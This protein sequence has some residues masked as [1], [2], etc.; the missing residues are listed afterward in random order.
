VSEPFF[1]SVCLRCAYAAFPA[2]LLCPSCGEERWKL[3]AVDEG[4]VESR[5]RLHRAPGRNYD[6]PVAIALVRV[7]DGPLVVARLEGDVASG[8]VTL[9]LEGGVPVARR[10]RRASCSAELARIARSADVRGVDASA[11]RRLIGNFATGVCVVTSSMHGA[12]R[13]CTANSVT[14]V[15]L[16][17]L[18]VLVCFDHG[19]NTLEAVRATGRFCLN[20]LAAGQE[21]ISRHFACK[22]TE[23]EK[24]GG[25]PYHVHDDVPVLDGCLAWIVCEVESEVPGGD[26]AIMLGRP[27]AGDEG[28]GGSPLVFFRSAYHE[29]DLAR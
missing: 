27:L 11:W 15:S 14:S 29:P 22:G 26:H 20:V 6:P 8:I 19:S 28:S 1:V 3:R 9:A 12:P 23:E 2:R 17:P 10:R 18:L 25:I 16:D 21:A 4:V 5:T 24:F 7:P 13:G